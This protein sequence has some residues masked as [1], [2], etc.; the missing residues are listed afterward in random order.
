MM[1]ELFIYI[2]IVFCAVITFI[3]FF[4]LLRFRKNPISND[5]ND[6]DRDMKQIYDTDS[7]GTE[8]KVLGRMVKQ[9]I[10]GKQDKSFAMILM[11]FILFLLFTVVLIIVII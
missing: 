9:Q 7:F 2:V 3:L 4:E 6:V 5:R 11:K 1:I 8:V 10:I